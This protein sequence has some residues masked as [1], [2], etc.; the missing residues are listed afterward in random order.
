MPGIVEARAEPIR[1]LVTG[2]PYQARLVLLHG[3][4]YAE[5]EFA[6]STTTAS[7]VIAHDWA[8][9]HSHFHDAAPDPRTGR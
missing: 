9:R 1:N 8:Q 3:F 2:E 5:A 4:E 6:S 7:G